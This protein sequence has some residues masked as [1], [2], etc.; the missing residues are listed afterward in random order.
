MQ[1]SAAQQ[2]CGIVGVW[3]D[4]QILNF[5]TNIYCYNEHTDEFRSEDL[6]VASCMFKAD[7]SLL[8]SSSL[9]SFG[10][11]VGRSL[12]STVLLPCCT[13]VSMDTWLLCHCIAVNVSRLWL[14][15]L[16]SMYVVIIVREPMNIGGAMVRVDWRVLHSMWVV[17]TVLLELLPLLH[18]KV[19]HACYDCK[20]LRITWIKLK[21]LYLP[22][23]VQ[24]FWK[25]HNV[26]C[27]LSL[28]TQ[29]VTSEITI[30]LLFWLLLTITMKSTIFWAV[31]LYCSETACH[32]WGKHYLNLQ[33][34][35]E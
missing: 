19:Q 25:S 14:Q 24:R 2:Y 12:G 22:R 4:N 21:I 23:I 29:L 11:T 17:P 30:K 6:Q 28:F 35:N 31:M 20:T 18:L 27:V 5:Y 33:L 10:L 9:N 3:R 8:H 26:L 7:D 32:F 15:L 13:A 16:C 34:V 1:R